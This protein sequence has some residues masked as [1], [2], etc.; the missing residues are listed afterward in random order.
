FGGKDDL[1]AAVIDEH[2]Q[3]FLERLR[4]FEA[5][6]DSAAAAAELL[7]AIARDPGQFL[8]FIEFWAY[9]ARTPRLRRQL[10]RR[11]ARIRDATAQAFRIRSAKCTGAPAMSEDLTVIL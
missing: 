6:E 5:A 11:L 4:K 9:A 3:W 7:D 1:F 8:V 2:V 10:A